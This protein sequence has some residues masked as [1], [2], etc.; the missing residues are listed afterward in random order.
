MYPVAASPRKLSYR[1]PGIGEVA[2]IGLFLTLELIDY[3]GQHRLSLCPSAL[4]T[5]PSISSM[6]AK[7]MPSFLGERTQAVYLDE[8]FFGPALPQQV[9]A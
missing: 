3:A 5:K 6:P 2:E 1:E 9:R 7:P 8:R 4:S